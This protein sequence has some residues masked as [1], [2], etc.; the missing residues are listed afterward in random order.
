MDFPMDFWLFS[1]YFINVL[2]KIITNLKFDKRYFIKGDLQK[3]IC[4]IGWFLVRKRN[5]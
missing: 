1:M 4:S 3:H 2:F 5:P